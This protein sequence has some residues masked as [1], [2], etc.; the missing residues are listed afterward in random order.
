MVTSDH[1][2]QLGDHGLIGKGGFFEESYRIAGVVRDPR[3]NARRGLVVE[4]FTEN[5]DLIPT[6]CEAMGLPVPV[7]LDGL[8][9][10]PLLAGEDLAVVA[11][12]G[13][14]GVRRS[15]RRYIGRAPHE[16]P[17]GPAASKRRGSC[18]SAQS[19][20][21]AAYAHFGDGSWLGFDLAADPTWRTP[22]ANPQAILS[23]AQAML[24]WRAEHADRTLSRN[25]LIDH[26][27][28]GR[29]PPPR[30]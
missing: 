5:I 1:G 25:A 15:A 26:G 24:T 12:G 9:L 4:R 17:W 8:P 23:E 7:Q 6:L 11:G 22:L 16:W 14:L 19:R 18:G 20:E 3:P 30:A 27:V 13:A 21:T 29:A 10:T 2:E 28:L